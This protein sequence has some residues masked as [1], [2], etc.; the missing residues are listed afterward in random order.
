MRLIALADCRTMPWKNGGGSTTAIAVHPQGAS[1]DD[2]DWRI[3]TAHVGTDG[4]FSTFPD[5]DRTLAVLTGEGIAL[6]FG[7]GET[8]R[9]DPDSPP[10][11]FAGDR[12]VEGRL[13]GGPIDDLNVM[14][15]RGRWRHSVRRLAGS[16]PISVAPAGDLM[17]LVARSAGW[18]IASGDRR[19]HPGAGDSVV[20]ERLEHAVL[21]SDGAGEIFAAH[22][23]AEGSG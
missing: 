6:A 13:V 20:L 3:S 16:G 18:T 15:R 1:L 4:P 17:V 14:T 22:L 11:A 9:L 8:V 12:I 7:D 19:E 10:C 5:I 23:W 21:S 2:F